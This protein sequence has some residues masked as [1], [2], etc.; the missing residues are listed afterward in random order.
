EVVRPEDVPV[1]G[2]RLAGLLEVADAQPG[3]HLTGRAAGG[4]DDP[5][6]VL[7]QQLPV[8]ARLVVIPFQAG[9]GRQPEEVVQAVGA[10]GPHGHVGVC[11]AATDVVFPAFGPAHPGPV[12]PGGAGGQVALDPDHR[13]DA[14]RD[15][16]LVEVVCAVE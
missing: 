1:V 12:E 14:G 16:L 4:G 15:G 9:P 11:A 6:R 2:R 7:L 13:L 8:G 10:G 3:L 5:F